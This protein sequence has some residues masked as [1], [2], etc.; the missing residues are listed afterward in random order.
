MEEI[1]DRIL[2]ISNTLEGKDLVQMTLKC[3]EELGE[4]SQAVLSHTDAP[5]CGY[6]NLGKDEIAEEIADVFIVN[7]AIAAKA[8]ITKEELKYWLEKKMIKWIDKIT[9][10]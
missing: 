2:E 8:G 3:G 6:K 9:G 10:K 7:V 5:G 4:L 1:V